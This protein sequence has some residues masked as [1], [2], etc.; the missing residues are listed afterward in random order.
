[1]P[2]F[3]YLFITFYVLLTFISTYLCNKNQCVALFMLSWP[4]N[5]QFTEKQNTY[6][7]LY[8][9]TIPP[10]DGLQICPKNVVVE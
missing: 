1:M 8:I 6:Q 3:V 9:Y 10:D 5:R 7:L 2:L 4:A